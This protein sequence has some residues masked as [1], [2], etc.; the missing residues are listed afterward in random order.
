MTKVGFLYT[1][2]RAEEKYL[3]DELEKRN[4]VEVVRIND[5]DSFFDIN[6][7]PQ[8]SGCALRAIHLLFARTVHLAHF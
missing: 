7:L 8:P 3:L 6:Q 2:L 5:G 4:D 1:R